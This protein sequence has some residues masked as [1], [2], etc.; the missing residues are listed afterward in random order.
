ML[1]RYLTGIAF[2]AVT[3]G[4]VQAFETTTLPL[5]AQEQPAFAGSSQ[6]FGKDY[7][8]GRYFGPSTFYSSTFGMVPGGVIPFATNTSVSSFGKTF[9]DKS[10]VATRSASGF[11]PLLASPGLTRG[12]HFSSAQVKAGYNLGRFRPYVAASF[13]SLRRRNIGGG[14][15]SLPGTFYNPAF[16]G[17]DTKSIANV[18]AGVDFAITNNFSVGIGVS[19]GTTSSTGQP[20]GLFPR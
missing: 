18:G 3:P 5:M 13:S 7:W 10:F 9:D 16:S 11:L 15:V 20:N 17:A 2:F 19:V 14:A 6:P 12:Y 8:K 4:L 1:L